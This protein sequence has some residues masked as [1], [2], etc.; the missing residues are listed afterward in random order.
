MSTF[1]RAKAPRF[2]ITRAVSLEELASIRDNLARATPFEMGFTEFVG[3][4]WQLIAALTSEPISNLAG[5]E[6]LNVKWS[7]NARGRE[8]WIFLHIRFDRYPGS[9]WTF[10]FDCNE[11]EVTVFLR[12]LLREKRLMIA[13][14]HQKAACLEHAADRLVETLG[15]NLDTYLLGGHED[16]SRN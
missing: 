12:R 7:A 5:D 9:D 13:F 6:A 3:E 11:S 2:T 14:P 10:A 15:N 16:L 4:T 8:K 1:R